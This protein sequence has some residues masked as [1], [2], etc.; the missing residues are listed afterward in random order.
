MTVPNFE[1]T[2]T[3]T[4]ASEWDFSDVELFAA[5]VEAL[6]AERPDLIT[7][8]ASFRYRTS[9]PRQVGLSGSSA[10]IIAAMRALATRRNTRWDRV[11]LA[12]IALAVETDILGWAAGPQDRVV[13]SYEGLLD[14]DFARPWNPASYVAQDLAL[15]P[16]LFVAWNQQMGQPSAVEHSRVRE[17]WLAGDPAVIE[18]MTAFAQLATTG[19]ASLDDRTAASAWPSLLEE[20]FELRSRIWNITSVDT[21][22]VETGMALGAGVAFAGSGGAVV[23]C[24]RD[25]NCLDKLA[26][27][28]DT[29]GAGFLV[30]SS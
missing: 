26:R 14:M 10:L 11:A 15:L 1:A 16:P 7:Q 5:C 6:K 18:A 23:G 28:Y 3:V 8:P 25:A 21:A 13:Q 4:E 17:R 27:A 9:I 22:L 30:L 20:A 2:V 24:P 29:I 19:R 12:R